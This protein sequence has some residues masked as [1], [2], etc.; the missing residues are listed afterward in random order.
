MA[1]TIIDSMSTYLEQVAAAPV[2]YYSHDDSLLS[3]FD[4]VSAS[5]EGNSMGGGGRMRQVKASRYLYRT[6]I[7]NY[8]G[9]QYQKL[10][11]NRGDSGNA[12][13][14]SYTQLQSGYFYSTINWEFTQEQMDIAESG[15]AAMV[16]V[17]VDTQSKIYATMLAHDNMHLFQDGK[18]FLTQDSSAG[19]ASTITFGAAADSLKTGRLFE[20]MVV[21]VW[22]TT[23]A[24]KRANGPFTITAINN[25][26]GACTLSAAPTGLVAT[27]RLAVAA[28]DV[29][30][31]ATLASFTAGWPA[32]GALTTAAGLTNDSWRHGVEYY[33][34]NTPTNYCL[35]KL[36]SAL[37]RL[38]PS[39]HNASS[40]TITWA[41]GEKIINQVLARWDKSELD[42]AQF[43]MHADQME[44]LKNSLTYI[45]TFQRS[46]G[47]GQ[48]FDLQPKGGRLGEGFDFAGLPAFTTR[49]A[50]RARVDM[51][52]P[53][54]W[55][56][57][58]VRAPSY[59]KFGGSI[60]FPPMS[61]TTGNPLTAAN[62]RMAQ[63]FDWANEKPGV[64]GYIYGLAF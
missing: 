6:V 2:T 36:K 26:T 63:G 31:P 54:N 64:S 34:D 30:G 42:G 5:G 40:S 56:R 57:V 39:V 41:M 15:Q 13:G 46:G 53:K 52:I 19:T 55:V 35:G 59:L 9:G 62:I 32:T 28:A 38:I 8:P 3:K 23:G 10:P 1:A 22:D 17:V 11:A 29:Y 12:T 43:Y 33:N 58:M 37:P 48:M 25:G 24:T 61:T 44:R 14:P 60:F 4:S 18:A 45:S 16:N 20:G 51:I 50:D 21:D 49:G 47:G 27:D 7:Q